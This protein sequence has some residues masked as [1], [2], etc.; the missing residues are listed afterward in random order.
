MNSP[1][2]S[3][4][5]EHTAHNSSFLEQSPR[6]SAVG[7]AWELLS[8]ALL[9]S[10]ISRAETWG[11]PSAGKPFAPPLD[12]IWESKWFGS[13]Q[14]SS[15]DAAGRNQSCTNR[16]S[17]GSDR[18][19]ANPSSPIIFSSRR[20]VEFP[21]AVTRVRNTPRVTSGAGLQHNNSVGLGTW[22]GRQTTFL[23]ES[24]GEPCEATPGSIVAAWLRQQAAEKASAAKAMQSE[25]QMEDAAW[26]WRFARRWNAEQT[27][28]VDPATASTEKAE[29]SSNA[30][31]L[32]NLAR[33]ASSDMN[34]SMNL[35]NGSII[36]VDLLLFDSDGKWASNRVDR[37]QRAQKLWD[38]SVS[39]STSL[40]PTVE[41]DAWGAFRFMVIKLCGTDAQER[42]I[43]HGHN[44]CS[45]A[46][47]MENVNRKVLQVSGLRGPGALLALGGGIM[48]WR[49][50]RD[51]YLQLHSGYCTDIN[52]GGVS[53]PSALLNLAAMLVKDS[54]PDG[55]EVAVDEE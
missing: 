13:G 39:A 35:K 26:R 40:L 29:E 19:G 44:H 9:G 34:S 31:N 16:T 41:I 50:D 11:H 49:R 24:K 5:N 36:G 27:R 7:S 10:P 3:F 25:D 21:P 54:L 15:F 45:D 38:N 28:D 42:I 4:C 37:E 17:D 55:Y 53:K 22:T 18:S 6:L 14:R 32:S 8:W 1:F 47:L 46:S 30:W 20:S 23:E 12:C 33:T 48:E 51:R 2:R 52:H 43:V